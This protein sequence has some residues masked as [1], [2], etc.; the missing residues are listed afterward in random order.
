MIIELKDAEFI[1]VIE[2]LM[3]KANSLREQKLPLSVIILKCLITGAREY[4]EEL[5]SEI[6]IREGY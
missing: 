5:D 3:E 6:R 1:A 2:K 4:E